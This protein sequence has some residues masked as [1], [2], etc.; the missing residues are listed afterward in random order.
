MIM[1][2]FVLIIV[3]VMLVC[4]IG[5]NIGRKV[6]KIIY[7]KKIDAAVTKIMFQT[8]MPKEVI[9]KLVT[10]CCTLAWSMKET[11]ATDDEIKKAVDDYCN[12]FIEKYLCEESLRS[13]LP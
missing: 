4:L 6:I 7:E 1:D 9:R 8:D 13:C 12:N 11:G 10:G 5:L 3:T 2:K